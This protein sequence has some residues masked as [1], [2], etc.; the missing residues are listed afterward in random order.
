MSAAPSTPPTK[1]PVAFVAASLIALVLVGVG[2][3][4]VRDLAVT[5]GWTTGT[6]WVPDLV[7]ALD[8]LTASAL[9]ITVGIV[10]AVVGVLLVWTVLRPA[11]RTHQRAKVDGADVWIS[12]AAV[13]TVAREA[14]DR[15]P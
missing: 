6:P 2:F 9:V 10:A 13:A 4:A 11:T 7:T 14:A 12:A 15:T 1:R 3:V 8:G 5:Q